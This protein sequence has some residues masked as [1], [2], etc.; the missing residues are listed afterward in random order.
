MKTAQKFAPDVNSIP[1]ARR[2]VLA[3]IGSATAEQRDAVSVMVSELAMNAGAP[4]GALSYPRCSRD[5]L[6][7]GSWV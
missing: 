2:F 1:A 4:R 5:E 6:E 7:G 3:A